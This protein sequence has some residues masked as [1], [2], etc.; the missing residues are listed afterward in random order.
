MSDRATAANPEVIRWAR[1]RAGLTLED[2]A[3]RLNKSPDDI[4]AWEEG[5]AA[6]TFLQL[7]KLA[8]S[9][10]DRPVGLFFFPEPPDEEPPEHEFRTLPEAE[11]ER[12]PSEVRLELQRVRALLISIRELSDGSNPAEQQ[13]WR[14]ISASVGDDLE[15]LAME[16]RE[17]L[18][19]DL[20]TQQQ[21]SSTRDAMSN[22][23]RVVEDAGVFVFK[24]NFGTEQVSGF[25]VYDPEFPVIMVN[26]MNTFTRQIFT[27]FH[28][29]AHVLFG[30]SGITP[31]DLSFADRIPNSENRRIETVCNELAAEILVPSSSFP[32]GSLSAVANEQ[33]ELIDRVT[34]VAGSFHVS[35]EVVMRRLLDRNVVD[36]DTYLKWAQEWSSQRSHSGK[37]GNYY[38]NQR[39]YLGQAFL[40]LAFSR[41]YSGDISIGELADHLG[42]KART[43]EEFEARGLVG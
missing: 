19:V 30:L 8:N 18:E 11:I 26:N 32:F 4:R 31:D 38:Y 37:G 43:V 41:Y 35:R 33:T 21:W 6:P 40:N 17:Y 13:I 14:D 29:L 25:C 27:L 15:D 3:D 34:T 28:E 36:R 12:L 39:A 42:M 23:R 7:E 22:W 5:E 16:I 24:D 10:Y 20:R 1:S 9:V 2:V